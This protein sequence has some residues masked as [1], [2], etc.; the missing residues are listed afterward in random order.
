MLLYI[1][2]FCFLLSIVLISFSVRVFKS[3]GYLACFFLLTSLHGF[4]IY[5]LYYSKSELMVSFVLIYSNFSIFLH[6]PMLYWYIRGTLTDNPTLRRNDAWHLLPA[7]IFFLFSLPY[8]FSPMDEKLRIAA[9]LV[10]NINNIQII[11]PPIL[12]PLI[13]AQLVF[14]LKI[15][16][17]LTYLIVSAWML[18]RYLKSG[19]KNYIMSGQ[20]IITKWLMVLV[21]FLLILAFGDSI[22][23]VEAFLTHDSSIYYTFNFL[24]ISST[25]GLIGFMI[26]PLFFPSILYGLPVIPPTSLTVSNTAEIDGLNGN[27]G[28]KVNKKALEAAYLKQIEDKIESAMMDGKVYLQDDLNLTQLS[29]LTQI[30]VHHLAYFFRE[31]VGITFHD[32]RNKWRVK[33]AKKLIR[34]GMIREM[35]LEAIGQMSGFTSR[36]TFFIAFKRIEGISPGEYAKGSDDIS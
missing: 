30:P 6:G 32:F 23:H 11:N 14:L 19:H 25:I 18:A 33:H 15:V 22:L 12:S 10:K 31:H 8:I 16:Q 17:P 2:I 4:N 28:Q 36:N 35:T 1:S 27:K 5:A 29:S 24:R 3:S 13:P 9:E 34:E 26:S 7:A 20:Q 21:G